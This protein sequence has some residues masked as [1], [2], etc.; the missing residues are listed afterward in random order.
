MRGE[1]AQHATRD[2][3]VAPQ[4]L[5]GRDQPVPSECRRVPGGAGIRITAFRRVGH[6]HLQIG[7]RPAEDLVQERIGCLDRG[8]VARGI[9]QLAPGGE[10]SLDESHR[11]LVGRLVA[12]DDQKDRPHLSRRKLEV[13]DG[14]A[15]AELVRPRI[16]AEGGGARGAVEA[17]IRQQCAVCT[18]HAVRGAAATRS[19]QPSHLEQVGEVASEKKRQRQADAVIAVI[20]HREPLVGAAAP[21]KDRSRDMQQVLLQHDPS[22]DEEVR[23]GEVDRQQGVVVAQVRAEQQRLLAVH[24]KFEM[25]Q[26]ARVVVKQPIGVARRGADVAISVHHGEGITVFER[27]A[28]P[29]RRSRCRDIERRLGNSV[30]GECC[31][32]GLVGRHGTSGRWCRD[33]HALTSSSSH[34]LRNLVDS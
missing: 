4:H 1:A 13:V 9:T 15:G 28:R 6:E 34:G 22:V 14:L 17:D 26:E 2:A 31:G 21:Q 16:E 23:V 24:Q 10:Q 8:C 32:Q 5:H 25:R 19:M 20:A 29:G 3:G 27:P 11:L 12:S 7:C 18:D 30:V 33:L